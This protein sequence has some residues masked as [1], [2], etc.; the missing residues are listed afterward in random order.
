MKRYIWLIVV[1]MILNSCSK[2]F[3]DTHS[4][5]SVDQDIV[6]TSMS[7]AR[8]ALNGMHRLMY[9]TT[10]TQNYMGYESMIMMNDIMGDDM[11]FAYSNT[12]FLTAYKWQ[13]HR[14]VTSGM[15]NYLY[16]FH[17]TVLANANM[18]IENIDNTPG[19]QED[20]DDIKGQA[21]AYRAFMHYCLVQWWGERYRPG[22]DNQQLGIPMKLSTSHE[23][24]A[25][26]T[27]EAV[28]ESIND[29]LDEA[30]RLLENAPERKTKMHINKY[31][32]L[33]LK[34]RVCLTQGRWEDA[35]HY[36]KEA[37]KLPGLKLSAD[38]Y[39]SKPKRFTDQ[40]NSEWMWGTLRKPEQTDGFKTLAAFLGNCDCIVARNSPKTIYNNL[41]S[42]ITA[43]DVRKNIWAATADI[44]KKEFDYA[45]NAKTPKYMANKYLVENK[46]SAA[47]DCPYMRLPEMILIEA[48]GYARWGG[49]DSEAQSALFRLAG[50]RDPQYTQSV[51]TGQD[52][53]EEI[54]LQ[55]RIEL[56]GE[57]FRFLDLKRNN[58]PLDRNAGVGKE[59]TNHSLT[60]TAGIM[61]VEAGDKMWQ[62]VFADNEVDNNPELVQNPL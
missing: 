11:C 4:T 5:S 34:A 56:W 49:H 54:W 17:Y 27:V 10:D 7:N 12:L 36:A 35:V 23:P 55:R 8:G 37:Q 50:F 59:A 15:N 39:T 61:R 41:Y 28:Y 26:S 29:D 33:G 57:G 48:E 40:S 24:Q 21:L 16:K 30:I 1:S 13:L 43:T 14:T 62:Y 25:R 32:A 58:L 31:V 60:Y 45:D 42:K 3:L 47:A 2:D 44:A 52:L 53:V 19:E 22:E 46:N 18:I 20:R 6:F 38:T 9:T 51:K